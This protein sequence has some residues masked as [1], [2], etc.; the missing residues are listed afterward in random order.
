MGVKRRLTKRNIEKAKASY[1]TPLSQLK[2]PS[3]ILRN[4]VSQKNSTP[5]KYYYVAKSLKVHGYFSRGQLVKS[6]VAMT[7]RTSLTVKRNIAR[8][9]SLGWI[10]K[11]SHGYRLVSYDRVWASLGY[12]TEDRLHLLKLRAD[13]PFEMEVACRELIRSKNAQ[14]AKLAKYYIREEYGLSYAEQSQLSVN[15][16]R[17][18]KRVAC[19]DTNKEKAALSEMEDMRNLRKPFLATDTEITCKHFATFLGRVSSHTGHRH[20]R[21][22]AAAGVIS[23]EKRELNLGTIPAELLKYSD[24]NGSFRMVGEELYKQLP[25]KI[26]VL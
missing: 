5:L 24:F 19:S 6:L 22:M 8:L 13:I 11:H 3:G 15:E 20:Q 9:L 4:A 1:Y 26:I 18:K 16:L 10:R 12:D 14:E 2:A 17:R 21:K 25:N 23:V 7:G